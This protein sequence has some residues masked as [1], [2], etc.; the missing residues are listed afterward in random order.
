MMKKQILFMVLGLLL[1]ITGCSGSNEPLNETKA[2]AK[3]E[4]KTVNTAQ[5]NQDLPNI[6]LLATGGTI[7]GADKSKTSTTNYKAGAVGVDTLIEAV[8]E[9]QNLANISGEQIANIGSQ[10]MTN[11]I[12]LKLSKRVGKLL[13]SDNVDG[14]VITHGTDTL[15]ETAYFLNLVIK[16]DKPVV[17]VGSMRPSTA[18]GADGP[19]NLYNAVKV[20]TSEEAKG[21]GTLIV[22]NDRIGA[23]RYVTKTNTTAP[24]TFQ[25]EEMGFLGNIADD[26]YFHNEV[27]KKHTIETDFD[28]SKIDKL[29]Q[30]DI[31]YGYQS[32]GRYLFDAAVKAG[33]KGIIYAGSGNGS[34]SDEAKK[35]AAA[36]V[37][38]GAAV[39]RSS[40][41][42]N[43]IV[44]PN[45]ELEKKHLLASNSLNP[46]KSR[47][48]LML[49]LTKTDDPEKIQKYFNEY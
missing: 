5:K 9:M 49:A 41:T 38:K 2:E 27:T 37:K 25:S 23:A 30:V 22:M 39:I 11:D 8:P 28:I 15:E 20:A 4:T 32:D 10:N 6:K 24:D 46:Q 7:A 26:I 13:S 47:I 35:G 19:A 40:R 43:G 45:P 48:L 31:I 33:A 42:G 21:K 44:T 36:A 1:M 14:I 29:P 18:I 34:I 16:S 17:V 3:T 12:L